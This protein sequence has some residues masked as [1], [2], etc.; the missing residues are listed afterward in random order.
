[1][2]LDV[3]EFD[4]LAFGGSALGFVVGFIVKSKFKIGHSRK[5]TVGIDNTDDFRL[6]D[7]VGWAD[8]HVEFFDNI[9]E[10]L[11]FAVLDSF[12]AP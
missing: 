9:E 3:I 6:D 4:G 1:M 2:E 7:V 8:E 10:E 12:G 11:I 5:L